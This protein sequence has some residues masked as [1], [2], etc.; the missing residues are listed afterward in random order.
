MVVVE[1]LLPRAAVLVGSAPA[2]AYQL[3]R[4][5]NTRLPLAQAAQA[6]QMGLLA[7]MALLDRILY[8]ARLL[9]QVAARVYLETIRLLL[10]LEETAAPAAEA[11]EVKTEAQEILH[12]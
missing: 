7:K 9:V 5:P 6:A 10:V 3:R 8:S 2:R 11:Q 12:L 1:Q 4:V